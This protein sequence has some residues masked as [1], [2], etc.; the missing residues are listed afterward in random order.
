MAFDKKKEILKFFYAVKRDEEIH[1]Y[2]SEVQNKTDFYSYPI[3]SSHLNTYKTSMAVDNP[4]F[5]NLQ[6]IELKLFCMEKN[7][8]STFANYD[9]DD[10]DDDEYYIDDDSPYR[11]FIPMHHSNNI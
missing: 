3:K 9:S 4:K 5:W 8:T 2:A 11:V 1:I 6:C 10:D 7:S